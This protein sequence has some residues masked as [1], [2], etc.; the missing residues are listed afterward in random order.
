M[1]KKKIALAVLLLMGVLVNVFIIKY[2]DQDVP[3]TV[4]LTCVAD[5]DKPQVFQ[6]YYGEKAEWSEKNSK[7]CS[8]D[9]EKGE[10]ELYFNIPSGSRY[11]RFDFGQNEGNVQLKELKVNC[12]GQSKAL[13]LLGFEADRAEEIKSLSALRVENDTVKVT[14]DGEDPHVVISLE[15]MDLK[16]FAKDSA[17]AR[18]R[19]YKPIMCVVIDLML[20]VFCLFYE[21][22]FS[23][24]RELY[25]NKSLIVKLAKNDFKTR[26]A[27]S[28]L[29]IFWAFVQPI[30][31]VVVY[32]FVFQVG[33]RS[34]STQDCPFVLWLVTGLIPWFFFQ[35]ALIGGTNS[36]MEYSYLVKKVV[37]KISV[38]PIVKIFA[39]IFVHLFFIGFTIILFMCYGYMPKIHVLQLVYYLFCMFV[40]V[41]ALSYATSAMVV[42]FKDLTQIIN[43]ILQVGVWMTP[44]M[45]DYTMLTDPYPAAMWI[46]K[47]NPMFYV[48]QGYRNCLIQHDWFWQDL[49]WTVYF[50]AVTGLLFVLGGLVFKRLKPHFSDVL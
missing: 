30:V 1:N 38:L 41:L 29:G 32:W 11:L 36:M 34:G 4:R 14:M 31:T 24:P 49:G 48:V 8:Y 43:I 3:E 13:D 25:Q 21:R 40:F 26:Y 47:A 35:E 10:Q 44:I 28:Y 50:W 18:D 9:D 23:L 46:L 22:L 20:L 27:G 7:T 6:V 42:F 19:I 37:F 15:G 2:G 17:A 39:S 16:A 12:Q 33:F 45:W 5:A